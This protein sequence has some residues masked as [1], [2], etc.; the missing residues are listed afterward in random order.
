MSFAKNIG[1]N[2]DK[3]ISK[4]LSGK[5][6]QKLLDHTK[7]SITDVAKNVSKRKIP[8]ATGDLIGNTTV[9]WI[10]KVSKTSP[11]DSLGQLNMSMIK[12]YLKKEI[13]LKETDRKLLMIWD[14][15][16]SIIMEYIY[17][18]N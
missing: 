11:Q 8:E 3:N 9:D 2:I 4:K 15:Y 14:Q 7:Q 13:Y 12:K 18:K 6:C 10:T 17:K 1:K 16:N 5:Y